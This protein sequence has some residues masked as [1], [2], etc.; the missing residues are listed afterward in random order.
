[1]DSVFVVVGYSQKYEETSPRAAF[2]SLEKA[3][4]ACEAIRKLWQDDT[5]TV[6]EVC[7]DRQF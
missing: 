2:S 1:M 5:E 6:V 7:L 4:E 3:Q